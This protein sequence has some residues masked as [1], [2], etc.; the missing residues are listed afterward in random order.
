MKRLVL[1][2][3]L[4]ASLCALLVGASASAGLAKSSKPPRVNGSFDFV[5]VNPCWDFPVPNVT[6]H[7]ELLASDDD[8]TVPMTSSDRQIDRVAMTVTWDSGDTWMP[9]VL[10]VLVLTD[11]AVFIGE[12]SWET[13]FSVYDGGNPGSRETGV[14]DFGIPTTLDWMRYSGFS[15]C[16]PSYYVTSGNINITFG[17]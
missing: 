6:G 8:P 4:L 16:H 3:L 14:G 10:G 5:Y 17:S 15:I 7:V 13:G 2:G 12:G 1:R 9:D 11:D